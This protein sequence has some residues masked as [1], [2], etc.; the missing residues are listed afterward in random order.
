[1]SLM[2]Q[3]VA[4]EADILVEDTYMNILCMKPYYYQ[5]CKPRCLKLNFTY[6]FGLWATSRNPQD[7][8]LAFMLGVVWGTICGARME[9][10]SAVWKAGTILAVLFLQ[11]PNKKKIWEWGTPSCTQGWLYVQGWDLEDYKTR[12]KKGFQKTLNFQRLQ[13]TNNSAWQIET[14][15]LD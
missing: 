4:G 10:G 1:M 9:P 7:L 12:N 14:T 13:H 11:P 5:Y 2:P 3:L 6:L 8:I 15:K